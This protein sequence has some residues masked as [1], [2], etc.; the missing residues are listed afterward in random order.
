MNKIKWAG[1]HV[2]TVAE[3]DEVLEHVG[4]GWHPL[5]TELIDDLFTLGW[6]GRLYQIKEKFGGLRFYT[7]EV[8]DLAAM[9]IADAEKESVKTCEYC[10]KEGSVRAPTGYWLKCVCNDHAGGV[11]NDG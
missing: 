2:E 3:L 7:G 9:R 11:K 8:S 1:G 10:G 4:E 6:D 5:V